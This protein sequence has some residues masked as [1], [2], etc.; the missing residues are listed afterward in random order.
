[1]KGEG[2]KARLASEKSGGGKSAASGRC[3]SED[4]HSAEP[5]TVWNRELCGSN[6]AV[7]LGA[8]LKCL[9]ANARSMGNK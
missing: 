8:Q 3:A 1:L 9:Y 2:D 6:G 7:S 5:V 4:L